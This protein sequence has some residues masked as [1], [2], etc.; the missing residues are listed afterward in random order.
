MSV[1]TPTVFCPGFGGMCWAHNHLGPVLLGGAARDSGE[2]VS[3]VEDLDVALLDARN[4]ACV[5]STRVTTLLT[6]RCID[7]NGS[8]TQ[9]KTGDIE[10]QLVLLP[11]TGAAMLAGCARS[12]EYS[13]GYIVFTRF[14]GDT[15]PE[16]DRSTLWGP[17][18]DPEPLL[19]A[20]EG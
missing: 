20:T 17:M 1:K 18:N 19:E 8:S 4:V 16:S 15:Q 12:D 10:P 13:Q 5:W 7:K 2:A 3:E 14:S 6:W 9:D 11:G